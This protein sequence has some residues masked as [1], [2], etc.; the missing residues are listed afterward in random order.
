MRSAIGALRLARKHLERRLSPL[1][2]APDLARPSRGW[3]KA[4]REALGMTAHQLGARIGVSQSRIARIERDEVEDALTLATL[5]R[6][7]EGLNCTLV[8]ALVPNDPLEEI[9]NARASAAA[10]FR[11]GVARGDTAHT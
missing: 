11:R 1:R 5:R 9:I 3:V 4:I 6:V 2:K 8:Y 7:A 10:A